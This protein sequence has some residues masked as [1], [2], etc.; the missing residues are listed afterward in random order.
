MILQENLQ[1]RRCLLLLPRAPLHSMQK[2][3]ALE[4]PDYPFGISFSECT[5][6]H[7][8]YPHDVLLPHSDQDRL[9]IKCQ[10]KG[11]RSCVQSCQLHLAWP[12]HARTHKLFSTFNFMCGI[13]SLIRVFDRVFGQLLKWMNFMKVTYPQAFTLQRISALTV[14]VTNYPIYGLSKSSK[15]QQQLRILKKVDQNIIWHTLDCLA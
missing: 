6:S 13:D 4:N 2:K 12:V 15:S 14:Q 11:S 10:L 5:I 1:R 8:K 9:A 7:R 3:L